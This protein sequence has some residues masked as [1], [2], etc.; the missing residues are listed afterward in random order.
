MGVYHLLV[1]FLKKHNRK[2]GKM[3]CLDETINS[4]NSIEIPEVKIEVPDS[5]FKETV[6]SNENQE[7]DNKELFSDLIN[8]QANSTS[9]D[10]SFLHWN[11]DLKNSTLLGLLPSD[12][13]TSHPEITRNRTIIRCGIEH[14]YFVR[15]RSGIPRDRRLRDLPA[16]MEGTLQFSNDAQLKQQT[17]DFERVTPGRKVVSLSPTN[18]TEES[19]VLNDKDKDKYCLSDGYSGSSSEDFS[20]DSTVAESDVR[21]YA[22]KAKSAERITKRV[23]LASG[24]ES[25]HVL[26]RFSDKSKSKLKRRTDVKNGRNVPKRL[27]SDE[28]K[29]SRV[30]ERLGTSSYP[31]RNRIPNNFVSVRDLLA[32]IRMQKVVKTKYDKSSDAEAKIRPPKLKRIVNH[33]KKGNEFIKMSDYLFP[34]PGL[35]KMRKKN[36]KI[37]FTDGDVQSLGLDDLLLKASELNAENFTKALGRKLDSTRSNCSSKDKSQ[38]L[39]KI[40]KT[41]SESVDEKKNAENADGNASKCGNLNSVQLDTSNSSQE[42][43]TKKRS[44]LNAN[45]SKGTEQT[46]P[47]KPG[48]KVKTVENINEEFKD[49]VE[50]RKT[51]FKDCSKAKM[52][53]GVLTETGGKETNQQNVGRNVSPSNDEKHKKGN[54]ECGRETEEGRNDNE[55]R[56]FIMTLVQGKT[57][58]QRPAILRNSTYFKKKSNSFDEDTERSKEATSR[59]V[60]DGREQDESS[61]EK[62]HGTAPGETS[63]SRQK[64]TGETEEDGTICEAS[65][66]VRQGGKKNIPFIL[67]HNR[68]PRQSDFS[69]CVSPSGISVQKQFPPGNKLVKTCG[70]STE[71]QLPNDKVFKVT[72]IEQKLGPKETNRRFIKLVPYEPGSK[73]GGKATDQTGEGPMPKN[74]EE[75]SGKEPRVSHLLSLGAFSNILKEILPEKWFLCLD[76]KYGLQ[77]IKTH[78]DDALNPSILISVVIGRCGRLTVNVRG[79][80]LEKT[81]QLFSNLCSISN[82]E[83]KLSLNYVLA[84]LNKLKYLS[85][86]IGCDPALRKYLPEKDVVD[87]QEESFR[88]HLCHQLVSLGKK[89]CYPCYRMNESIKKRYRREKVDGKSRTEPEKSVS[90]SATVEEV[91]SGRNTRTNTPARGVKRNLE[92]FLEESFS[93]MKQEISD[94]IERNK[95][96]GE[97]EN[98][99]K[100]QE[101]VL[102]FMGLTRKDSLDNSV[103]KSK[104][105]KNSF[106]KSQ[107]QPVKK[108]IDQKELEFLEKYWTDINTLFS[109]SLLFG[110]YSRT[111]RSRL[112]E[113]C[114]MF[115]KLLTTWRDIVKTN[116][117]WIGGDII[118]PD[119]TPVDGSD[120]FDKM[121]VT[122][123]RAFIIN[124]VKEV[125]RIKHK[126]RTRNSYFKILYNKFVKRRMKRAK[127][128][129]SEKKEVVSSGNSTATNTP[130][131]LSSDESSREKEKAMDDD[132]FQSAAATSTTNEEADTA[133]APKKTPL[134]NSEPDETDTK[135][136]EVRQEGASTPTK[137]PQEEDA[138]AVAEKKTDGNKLSDC[139]K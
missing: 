125:N 96:L 44:E 31:N 128:S 56:P 136:E 78:L 97:R 69:V 126:L 74:S 88:S 43:D 104:R 65:G 35:N 60:A 16:T 63:A 111:G 84:I 86:C 27:L 92:D 29:K 32:K 118:L 83:N 19:D 132:G 64:V 73:N 2:E 76:R 24:N 12:A 117:E 106:F 58:K 52:M 25:V 1:E 62:Q 137:T 8:S 112:R 57:E 93:T 22:K 116:P 18:S 94:E 33:T 13:D 105:K 113:K 103:R 134:E 61:S 87:A 47:K 41:K 37:D 34:V 7:E 124:S 10:L 129:G 133:V 121:D 89:R 99:L 102:S 90:Q 131:D 54:S 17:I 66:Q 21:V 139:E 72:S 98:A 49:S 127:P 59:I 11:H 5:D 80:Q 70:E 3:E 53:K 68:K 77:I 81:H 48:I 6:I 30:R 42:S 101:E 4:S 114:R 39:L 40:P 46:S 109:T 36:W 119:Q 14:S 38:L 100:E 75:E 9:Q 45:G 82:S 51:V 138:A 71:R 67:S 130:T 20:E 123:L 110:A 135:G 50:L 108:K 115:R 15:S 107:S 26:S 79:K 95:K 55:N 23:I 85:V 120:Q 122:A 28:Q 91:A